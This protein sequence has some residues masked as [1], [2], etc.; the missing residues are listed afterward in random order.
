MARAGSDYDKRCEQRRRRIE[1]R[2]E[3]QTIE[4]EAHQRAEQRHSQRQQHPAQPA[5][6]VPQD[7]RDDQHE[8]RERHG[9]VTQPDAVDPADYD[10]RAGGA[11]RNP[12]ALVLLE[13]YLH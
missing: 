12:G 3:E 2:A 9:D 5:E 1:R 8:K 7:H 10:R 4:P 6:A 13:Q 11:Q